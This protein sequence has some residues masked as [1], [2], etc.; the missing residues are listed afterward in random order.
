MHLPGVQ[1]QTYKFASMMRIR[2]LGIG[3]L[4]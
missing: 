3:Q 2:N 1:G 4:W